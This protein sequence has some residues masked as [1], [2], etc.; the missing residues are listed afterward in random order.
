MKP[1]VTEIPIVQVNT[2]VDSCSKLAF[3]CW[4]T[5]FEWYHKHFYLHYLVNHHYLHYQK[6]RED[7]GKEYKTCL[8][9]M[10]L[11]CMAH[12]EFQKAIKVFILSVTQ[13]S[14]QTSTILGDIEADTNFIVKF[15]HSLTRLFRRMRLK[16]WIS[17]C[18]MSQ[19]VR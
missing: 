10:I 15:V 17:H 13:T 6:C 3:S 12:Q 11:M 8:P 16:P 19:H 7:C 2:T 1:L 4:I 9:Q 14:F 18:K 5:I